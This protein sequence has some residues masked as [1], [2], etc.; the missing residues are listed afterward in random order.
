MIIK[1]ETSTR[2]FGYSASGNKK[3][4]VFINT[5]HIVLIKQT[6]EDY[7]TISLSNGES[8]SV[9]EKNIE[10]FCNKTG[11]LPKTNEEIYRETKKNHEKED[12]FCILRTRASA[13]LEKYKNWESRIEDVWEYLD[14][15]HDC[16]LSYWDNIDMA[17]DAIFEN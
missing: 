6:S 5:D 16:T 1:I 10:E 9:K 7:I 14:R 13:D 15:H 3:K 2:D 11:I 8:V 4:T 12:I 17:A